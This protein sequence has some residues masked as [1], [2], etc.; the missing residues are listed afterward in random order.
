MPVIWDDEEAGVPRPLEELD[1]EQLIESVP[2]PAHH[3]L[4]LASG[5]FNRE[6]IT[7]VWFAEIFQDLDDVSVSESE[8]GTLKA[9]LVDCLRHLKPWRE[10][11]GL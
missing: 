4:R 1:V 8:A 10:E 7:C 11:D 5:C 6:G 2:D 9:A 3:Y